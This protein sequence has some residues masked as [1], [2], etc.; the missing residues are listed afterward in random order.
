MINLGAQFEAEL[1]A[2]A[3]L[4]PDVIDPGSTQITLVNPSGPTTV[5]ATIVATVDHDALNA[6]I[7][8]YV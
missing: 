1:I 4:N 7:T 5:R 8:K 6:L 2:L 3:G